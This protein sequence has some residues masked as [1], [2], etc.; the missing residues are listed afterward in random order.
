MQEVSRSRLSAIEDLKIVV[1]RIAA[2][3][4]EDDVI[5]STWATL[6]VL[7]PAY[8]KTTFT[9]SMLCRREKKKHSDPSL[10]V[11]IKW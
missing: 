8:E 11:N 4:S 3:P 2:Q 7:R 10:Y 5:R 1:G 6:E 9:L